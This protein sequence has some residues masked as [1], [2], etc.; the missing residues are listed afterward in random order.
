MLIII[1]FCSSAYAQMPEA[2]LGWKLGAQAW[3]FKNVTFEQALKKADS[4]RLKY[5]EAYPKQPIGGNIEGIM[6]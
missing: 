4:C 5:I 3:T 6:D 2:K 1:K